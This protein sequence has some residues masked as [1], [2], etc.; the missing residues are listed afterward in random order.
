MNKENAL[1]KL[2]DPK[3]YLEN[4]TKIKGKD[5][6]SLLPFKL[7]E[8][9][10]D[11]FNVMREKNRIMILKARQMGFSTATVGYFY[12]ST[13]M[14]P[15]TNTALIGYNSDLTAELLEKVKTFYKSTPIELRPT[16][17]YNSKSEI[18]FPAIDSKILIL[19][20][21]VNVGRGYTIHN[22]LSGDTNVLMNDS[23]VKNIKDIKKGD[24]VING[25]GGFSEVNA[26]L[27]SSGKEKELYE[28]NFYGM[29]E[30][31]KL[32]GDHKVLTRENKTGKEVW[33]E[34]KD[35]TN[36]DYIAYPYY[37]C[38][39]RIKEV[40]L[41]SFIK[42]GY[43]SR[44]I[45]T[46]KKIKI[47]RKLGEVI[48]WYLAEG[49][50]RENSFTLSIHRNEV[51]EVLEVLTEIKQYVGKI[52]TNYQ[53]KDGKLSAV[54]TVYGKNFTKFLENNFGSRSSNKR[55]SNRV[56]Y[57]GWDFS[58]GIIDGLIKGDGCTKDVRRV[59]LTTTSRQLAEGLRR[60]SV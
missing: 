12:H 32:T 41:E 9:Q 53:N 21:T 4:F 13:I 29:N 30:K 11:I 45:K 44:S 36:K 56:W 42:K 39:N 7:R 48:G 47:T 5:T 46:P 58:F 28:L 50:S 43:E 54:I 49:T 14:K 40:P 19:P 22:C 55:I 8:A 24:K 10:K 38:K 27:I 59:T 51:N 52:H 31:L 1:L 20:S 3:F 34:T 16:I 57:W 2:Q 18:S 23:S 17:Q 33:K 15:C 60:L 25:R 37:L 26:T 35:I 6:G